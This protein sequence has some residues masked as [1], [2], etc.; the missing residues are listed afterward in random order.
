MLRLINIKKNYGQSPV[1]NIDS[2]QLPDAI[3]WV[4]GTNGSG[5]TTLLKMVAGLIPFEGEISFN[6]INLRH[7][8]LTYRQHVSWAEAEPL[9]PAFMTGMELISL[10]CGIRKVSRQ[11]ADR[12][13]ERFMMTHY[14][15]TAI[16]TYS[17]GMTKKLSLVLA[18][19]GE[20]PLVVLDE[21]LITLDLEALTSVCTYILE[22]HI[23]TG[24]TFLMS[25]HQKLNNRLLLSGK[26]LVVK[27]RTV[28]LG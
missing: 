15:D 19:L 7:Q 24:A 11:D 1:L 27:D 25:S 2:L 17:A 14:V 12:L 8:P 4:K 3:Y 20:L 18:F 26:E 6:E 10:Y 21:P 5:K 9:F 13:L 23:N 28:L 22:R 16:G